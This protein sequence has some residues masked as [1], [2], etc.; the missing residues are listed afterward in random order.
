MKDSRLKEILQ[1]YGGLIDRYGWSSYTL[2]RL[3]LLESLLREL[4]KTDLRNMIDLGC[5]YKVLACIIAEYLNISEVYGVDLSEERLRVESPCNVITI[6]ADLT[7]PLFASS[8]ESFDLIV[9]FG[10]IEH[11]S[12]WDTFMENVVRLSHKGSFLLISAP[13]LGSWI[14]RGLLLLGFQPRDLEISSKRLYGVAPLYKGHAPVGHVKAA[15]LPAMRQFIESYGF[16]VVR[17]SSLYAKDNVLTN[18]VDLLLKPFPSLARRYIILAQRDELESNKI[19][20]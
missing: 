6:N 20:H 11:L 7:K 18:I 13:N 8:G 4:R 14:N 17:V 15:T 12:D 5:G 3:D 9:S 16:R 1:K 19:Y 2:M 10:V